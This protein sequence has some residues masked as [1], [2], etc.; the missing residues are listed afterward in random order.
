MLLPRLPAGSA[1]LPIP[2]RD[3][4]AKQGARAQTRDRRHPS[5]GRCPAAGGGTGSTAPPASRRGPGT[6]AS[7]ARVPGSG[8]R[9]GVRGPPGRRGGTRM[10]AG[11]G[12]REV[13]GRGTRMWGLRAALTRARQLRDA[14]KPV[15]GTE[16][17]PGG[18]GGAHSLFGVHGGGGGPL[19]RSQS[20]LLRL[21]FQDGGRSAPEAPPATRRRR[22]SR[23]MRW[24]GSP[25]CF[26]ER[27]VSH[28]SRLS[29]TAQ[30]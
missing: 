1:R 2:T 28:V 20:A 13:S 14:S 26:L 9:V 17:A 4:F 27:V 10:C 18:A 11:G 22:R 16:A 23:R 24:G 30:V 3:E 19:G 29:P 15:L 7:R 21:P 8:C 5:R 12:R 6:A 25:R